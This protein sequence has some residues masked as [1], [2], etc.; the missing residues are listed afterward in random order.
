MNENHMALMTHLNPAVGQ[1]L[2]SDATTYF[3]SL[4]N[5][6]LVNNPLTKRPWGKLREDVPIDTV[7]ILYDSTESIRSVPFSRF[8]AKPRTPS[9]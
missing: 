1:I 2:I 7:I 8:Q 5:A 4:R 6:F 9:C 3:P